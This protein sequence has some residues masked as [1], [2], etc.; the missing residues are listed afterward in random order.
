MLNKIT[1][2]IGIILVIVVGIFLFLYF[3]RDN[4]TNTLSDITTSIRGFFPFGK[5]S[6]ATP[7]TDIVKTNP[8]QNPVLPDTNTAPPRLRQIY[9]LPVSGSEIFTVASSTFVRFLEKS[10]GNVY[11][12][13]TDKNTVERISNT[14]IPK[15]TEAVFVKKDAV[16]L[17]YLKDDS[18]I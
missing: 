9:S 12:S 17:R 13:K 2:I 1:I 11:E 7:E 10:T 15:V 18:D 6:A 4:K 5:G 16:L 14:T 3:T 8:N